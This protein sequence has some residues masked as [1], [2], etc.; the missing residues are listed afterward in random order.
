[1][2]GNINFIIA[3]RHT[4]AGGGYYLRMWMVVV[5]IF[6]VLITPAPAFIVNGVSR[7]TNLQ[8]KFEWHAT[9]LLN[10]H[11]GCDVSP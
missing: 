10:K 7:A 5:K 3:G 4:K 11:N 2:F 1:M 9:D 8:S 6:Y